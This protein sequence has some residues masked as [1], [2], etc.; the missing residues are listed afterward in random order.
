ME[1]IQINESVENDPDIKFVEFPKISRFNRDIMITE[2]LDG[3]NAAICVTPNGSVYAQSRGRILTP[4][5]DNYGFATWVEKNKKLLATLGPGVHFGEWWG[6]GIGRGYELTERRF[7]LFNATRWRKEEEGRLVIAN[8][9]RQGLR[10]V[11]VVPILYEGPWEHWVVDKMQLASET[12]IE[13]LIS[14]G[15]SAAPGYYKPEGIVIFH[16]ASS[17]MYKVTC[18][19][20]QEWKGKTNSG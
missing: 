20:D 17:H 8:I 7:W 5:G 9:F 18:E 12:V 6:V 19:K 11:D 13:R 15:S 4:S 10:N 3:T 14:T 16:K 1:K 2:K